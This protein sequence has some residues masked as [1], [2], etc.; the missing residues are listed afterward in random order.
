MDILID[1]GPIYMSANIYSVLRCVYFPRMYTL[2]NKCPSN[3]QITEMFI[4]CSIN[5]SFKEKTCQE[6]G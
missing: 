3:C 4:I 2:L 1:W 6:N 5:K